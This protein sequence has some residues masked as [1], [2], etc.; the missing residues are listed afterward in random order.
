MND[1]AV[2]RTAPAT[3]GLLIKST[4]APHYGSKLAVILIEPAAWRLSRS[5]VKR[6]P[7][8]VDELTSFGQ[9]ESAPAILGLY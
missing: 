8:L 3:P 7:T 1:E 9:R 2:Y 6:K 5:T 4:Q